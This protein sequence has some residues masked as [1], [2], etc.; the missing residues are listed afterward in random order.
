MQLRR[1]VG[2]V[3]HALCC[4]CGVISPEESWTY[5]QPTESGPWRR[6]ICG[7]GDPMMLCPVCGWE[8]R[9]IDDGSGVYE[10]TLEEMIAERLSLLQNPMWAD[11]W[12]WPWDKK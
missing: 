9:D 4:N 6:S 5:W 11:S 12:I 1:W 3:T 2:R 10:G 8:H 7:E